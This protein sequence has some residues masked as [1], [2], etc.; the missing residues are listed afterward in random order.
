[1]SRPLQRKHSSKDNGA[2]TELDGSRKEKDDDGG[3]GEMEIPNG[4]FIGW[5]QVAGSFF[6]FF[7]TW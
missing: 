1:M 4:G 2:Q 7:N 3:H 6:I 5:L